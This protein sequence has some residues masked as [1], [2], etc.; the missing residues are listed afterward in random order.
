MKMLL[1]QKETCTTGLI[2]AWR[3]TVWRLG[4][5]QSIKDDQTHALSCIWPGRGKG[6]TDVHL[7]GIGDIEVF[8]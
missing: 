3:T 4:K 8:S 7:G 2:G 6:V 5:I 1:M